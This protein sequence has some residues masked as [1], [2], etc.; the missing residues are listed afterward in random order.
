ML[1]EQQ[2]RYDILLNNF[3][4]LREVVRKYMRLDISSGYKHEY[5]CKQ[6]NKINQKFEQKTMIHV[7]TERFVESLQ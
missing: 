6:K 5:D 4:F 3:Q 2:E 1:D 7:N